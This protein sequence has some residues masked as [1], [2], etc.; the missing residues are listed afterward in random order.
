M[1]YQYIV[2]VASGDADADGAALDRLCG[3]FVD[4]ARKLHLLYIGSH[5][6]TGF[7]TVTARHHIAND[8]QVK[9]EMFP[10][11]KRLCLDRG[12]ATDRIHIEVGD[13]AL[14]IER[15]TRDHKI[16]LLAISAA[17]DAGNTGLVKLLTKLLGVYHCDLHIMR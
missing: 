7:G 13:P 4:A 14:V 11:L 16:D 2:F 6:V 10:Q 1:G 8:M 9:Q 15:Y 17:T 5:H 3:S 12:I